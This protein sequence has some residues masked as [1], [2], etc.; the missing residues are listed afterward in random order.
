MSFTDLAW[1]GFA[2]YFQLLEKLH[3][4]R[5]IRWNSKKGCLEV[6]P[7][8]QTLLWSVGTLCSYVVGLLCPVYVALEHIFVKRMNLPVKDGAF[9]LLLFLATVHTFPVFLHTMF[10]SKAD[11]VEGFNNI[12]QLEKHLLGTL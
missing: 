5:P 3:Y 8:P 10:V 9:L 6:N 4:T 12:I 2:G 7:S 11:L 1:S